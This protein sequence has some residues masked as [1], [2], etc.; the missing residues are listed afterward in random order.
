MKIW[1]AWW[2]MVASCAMANWRCDRAQNRLQFF[3][4]EGK[5]LRQLDIDIDTKNNTTGWGSVY[6]VVEDAKGRHWFVADGTNNEIKIVSQK[7]QKVIGTVGRSGRNAGDFH[8]LHN[9][10]IDSHGNLYTSEVDSGKRVQKF[11]LTK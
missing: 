10:A 7:S 1:I 3:T 11:T 6:D 5:F 2:M 9:I 4:K 8:V